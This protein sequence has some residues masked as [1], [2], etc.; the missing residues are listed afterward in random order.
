M[1]QYEPN[2]WKD[3]PGH[4][5]YQAS[6][7]GLIRNKN[8]KYVLTQKLSPTE[9]YKNVCLTENGKSKQFDVHRLVA[10][11]F[12][13]GYEPGL[14]VNHIDGNK[15]NNNYTN[16]EWCTSKHNLMHA[17]NNDLMHPGAYQKRKI[18]VEE[19][20]EIFDGVVDCANHIQADFRNVYAT[21][22]GDRPTVNGLHLKYY[23]DNLLS[24]LRP[25]Q[26]D[27]ARKMKNGCI[28]NGGVGSGKSRTSLY[29]YIT[30]YGGEM[31]PE[32][33]PMINPPDLY[34]ITT[35]AKRD[36]LEWDKE[37]VPFL[38][39]TNPEVNGYENKVIIDS[40]NNIKKY[41]DV[42][43]AFFI[44][45]EDRVTG[46]GAWVK[47]FLKIAK[48]NKWIILSATPGDKYEDYIPV[49]IAN[50]FYKNK[51]EFS[52]EHLVYSRFTKFPKVERYLNTTRLNRLRRSILIDM[53]FNRNTI[54]HHEDIFTYYDIN[55]Y[56]SVYRERWNPF[57]NKPINNASEFC[58]ILRKI[59]NSDES[60]QVSILELLEKHPKA[61]I[62]YNFDYE[63]EILKN[64]ADNN[65]YEYA[66]W[67]GHAH[68]P[69]PKSDRWL[70]LVQY[71]AGCEGWSC[72]TTNTIIFYSQNYSYKML[73]QAAGRIDRM[74]TPF[75]DLYFYHLKSRS[76]IDLAINRALKNKKKF[77]ETTFAEKYF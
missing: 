76:G 71:T 21:V 26:L 77:N 62:F 20:G 12:C 11:T 29:Y 61:I 44:F 4:S 39:S 1:I 38:L 34:I 30:L 37:L 74:N 60:R 27:A 54:S 41:S 59:V 9:R 50:G 49:F 70:Y 7:E 47:A 6:P 72:I 65:G 28:L 73:V 63:L 53:E 2:T 55:K 32:F 3:I 56:K 25:H 43:Y 46:Y 13:D 52:Q 42:T 14:V 23:E 15:L 67:N 58:Y 31:V 68:Q 24:F 17:I 48:S 69:V 66:E 57:D 22:H 19:T 5:N 10:L 33:K 8:T 35:A 16:L 51:T 18:L 40:W 36:K 64:L 75:E 45:D